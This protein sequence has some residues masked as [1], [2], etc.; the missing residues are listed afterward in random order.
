M[1]D[2]VGAAV[3]DPAEFERVLAH[4]K[5]LVSANQHAYVDPDAL[6]IARFILDTLGATFPCGFT[7][8]RVEHAPDGAVVMIDDIEFGSRDE[9]ISV[10]AAIVRCALALP[11]DK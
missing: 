7:Q 6:W 10:A 9:A 1:T 2:P 4:C 11:E 8:P 5:R 3:T